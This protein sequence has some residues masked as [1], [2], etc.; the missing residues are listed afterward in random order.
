MAVSGGSLS[1]WTAVSSTVYTATFTPTDNS[2][3]DG[4]ISVASSKFSDAAGNNNLDGADANNSV[5][6]TVDTTTSSSPSPAPAQDTIRPSIAITHDDSDD[7]LGI[8]DS[9][10]IAFTLSEDST[11][12]SETD[13]T[14]S[15]GTLS[16][17]SGSGSSYSATFTPKAD[18]RTEAVIAVASGAFSNSV[19]N[20]NNDGTDANNTVILAVDTIVN[21]SR[22]FNPKSNCHISSSNQYEIDKLTREQW[23]N[24]GIFSTSPSEK[25]ENIYRFFSPRKGSHLY[26]SS[27]LEKDSIIASAQGDYVYEG[28]A[29]KAY[30]LE[31][32]AAH[33]KLEVVRFF[34]TQSNTHMYSSSE[35]E[36]KILSES[37]FFV[38]EGIAW[39][40]DFI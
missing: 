23:I 1:N 37:N 8:G 24:E 10:T 16:N 22:L 25:S 35:H 40:S 27:E 32:G 36:C 18:S 31:Y 19:G 6:F 13:V 7:F 5:T 28:V 15:G 17:F 39:Y 29:F 12:F 21:V 20:R 38:N 34:N 4:V 2:T 9:T 26:T 11:D 33:G 14:I 3:T 30:S